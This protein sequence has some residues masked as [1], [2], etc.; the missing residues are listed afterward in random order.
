MRLLILVSI[1]FALAGGSPAGPPA[2]AWPQFRGG[3]ELTGV[4]RSNPPDRLR[5][6]W[7]YEAGDAIESSAA[8]A[9]GTVFVGAQSG[10][11]IALTLQDGVVRWTYRT[12]EPI[13][14]SSPAVGGGR[15]YIGDLGGVLHAVNVADGRAAWTFKT[16]SE[17]KSSPVVAG[18]G[19]DRVLIGSYDGHLYCLS[20]RD[21]SLLWKVRTNGYVHGTPAVRDGVAYVAGCDEIFRAIRIADGKE[22]LTIPVGAYTAASVALAGNLVYFGTFENQVLALDLKAR[23][24]VWRYQRQ[25]RQFPFYSS[26]ALAGGR[27]VVGGRDKLIHV[28]DAATGKPRWTFATRARVDSSPAVAGRRIYVGSGDNRFYV[29]DLDTGRVVWEY[30]AGAP[31]SASPAI[32]AGRVVIGAQDGRL[33]CFG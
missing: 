21:G 15:V 16:E 4:A 24:I 13:G 20:A 23:R 31:I 19:A 14:E 18:E 12:G 2:D 32:A 7:T 27:V 1:V 3:H 9:D 29:L 8:I 26:A 11:L 5:L 10:E 6:L 25:D 17:I 22:L 28:L 33:L 30:D